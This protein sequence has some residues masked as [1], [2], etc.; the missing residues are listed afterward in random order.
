MS[1]E[2]NVAGAIHHSILRDP[3]PQTQNQYVYIAVDD[4]GAAFRRAG[5][6]GATLV[7]EKVESMPWGE[8]LFYARD[9]SGNPICFVDAATLFLGEGS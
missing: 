4:I 9:P 5:E 2:S 7:S 3:Q 8:T 6:L 1:P